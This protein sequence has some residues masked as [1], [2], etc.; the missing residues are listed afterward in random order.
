MRA[1]TFWISGVLLAL[2]SP[3]PAG[4]TDVALLNLPPG[5]NADPALAQLSPIVWAKA[6]SSAGE[7]LSA[8]AI[9]S[10]GVPPDVAITRIRD[11]LAPPNTPVWKT[12]ATLCGSPGLV[13][14]GRST[15]GLP[16]TEYVIEEAHSKLYLFAYSHAS[17]TEADAQAEQFMRDACPASVSALLSLTPPS[18]WLAKTLIENIGAWQTA[19]GDSIILSTTSLAE[20][21]R[22]S[23]A[24]HSS[25]NA[26][27]AAQSFTA[28]SGTGFQTDE[29][30]H[31]GSQ[32]FTLTVFVIATHQTAYI[33]D[34]RHA[35][36][37]DPKVVTAIRSYCPA[38][39][40]ITG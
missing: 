4:A 27:G 38:D 32:L 37:P 25:A 11:R 31:V 29:R 8:V 7:T 36:E 33:V 21:A 14:G 34:Y 24:L 5:W 10:E 13:L 22:L 9:P 26:D 1:T 39:A 15:G 18:G 17:E 20:A 16:V 19:S 2:I 6:G 3:F 12:Q 40:S 30:G 23:G 28:C 35:R